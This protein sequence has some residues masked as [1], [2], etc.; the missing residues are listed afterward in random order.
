MTFISDGWGG[1][2]SDKHIVEKSG[3]LNHL[4][5]GDILMADRGFKIA[6]DVAFYQAKL[7]IPDFTK[8]EKQLHPL[9]VENTRGGIHEW[10]HNL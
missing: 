3:I 7:V 8:G 6:D 9:E 2:A 10:G 4:L 5:P 1:C